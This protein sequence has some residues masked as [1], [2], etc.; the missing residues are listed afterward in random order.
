[1]WQIELINDLGDIIDV[2]TIDNEEVTCDDIAERN[3][4]LA[5]G[6]IIRIE[7]LED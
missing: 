7:K 6:D 2:F 1:M 5:D 4:S 3:W